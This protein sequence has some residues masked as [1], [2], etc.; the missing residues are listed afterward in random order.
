MLA[1]AQPLPH[2]LNGQSSAEDSSSFRPLKDIDAFKQHL[3]PPIEFVQGSSTGAVAVPSD[4]YECINDTPPTNKP[5]ASQEK[6]REELIIVSLTPQSNPLHQAPESA[7]PSPKLSRKAKPASSRVAPS[8]HAEPIDISWPDNVNGVGAGLFNTG[9]TCFMNSALQC[10]F[11]TPPLLRL[12]SAHS[13]DSC[14]SSGFCMACCMKYTAM[15]SQSSNKSAFNPDGITRNLKA[16]AKSLRYGRQEDSHE[17]LRH[18][19]EGLQRSCLAGQPQK[20]D[21]KLAET[22]WVHQLFGGQ[23]RSRVHCKGCGHNS[24]TYDSILDLSLDIHRTSSLKDALKSFVAPDYLKGSDKYK[25]DHCKKYVNAEKRFTIN[26]APLV[27]TIHLKRFSPFGSK[28]TNLLHYD[29]HIT[30]KP[31]MSEGSFGPRY[32]LYGVICHS[33]SGPNSGHY[34][35]FVKSKQGRWYEMNDESV[36]PCSKPYP[37]LKTAYML[38]YIQ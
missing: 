29:E 24:D 9:N 26:K 11:H 30:L 34:F 21:P 28:L 32:S 7:P 38:M 19:I 31:Y 2:Q 4:K 27:L 36:T 33:G 15:R 35:S 37:M 3:P 18:A 23:L 14:K 6:V 12:L 17:F 16:F 25:C 1:V 5:G 10:L 22:S 20:V 13:K 8:L